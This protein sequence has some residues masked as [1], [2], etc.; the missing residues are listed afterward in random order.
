MFAGHDYLSPYSNRIKYTAQL[1]VSWEVHEGHHYLSPYF[2]DFGEEV[3]SFGWPVDHTSFREVK[4]T[5]RFFRGTM[6][7]PFLFEQSGH[8]YSAYE[9]SFPCSPGLSGSP[10]FIPTDPLAVIGVVAANLRSHSVIEGEMEV[11]RG[12]ETT[13]TE[14]REVINYGVASNIFYA[15]EAIEKILGRRLPDPAPIVIRGDRR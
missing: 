10:V 11:R 14:F 12:S 5:L 2:S 8:R 4:E 7:R 9:L 6:Q 13:K 1:M 3:C 15:I